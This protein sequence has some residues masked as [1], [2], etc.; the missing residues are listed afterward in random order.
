MTVT[1]AGTGMP[2]RWMRRATLLLGIALL[3]VGLT[4]GF[5]TTRWGSPT[6]TAARESLLAVPRAGGTDVAATRAADIVQLRVNP[7]NGDRPTMRAARGPET[8]DAGA[9]HANQP[10]AG[11]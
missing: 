8:I 6:S 9:V 3:A 7:G 2:W 5:L 10:D 11:R 4:A 1:L